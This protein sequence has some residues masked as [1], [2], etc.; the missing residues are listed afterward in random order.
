VIFF[1]HAFIT[2]IWDKI[3]IANLQK[4]LICSSSWGDDA[5]T[6]LN[7]EKSGLIMNHAYT[8]MNTYIITDDEGKEIKLLKIKNP[9]GHKEWKGDWS[10]EWLG[11]NQS[12]LEEFKNEIDF[13]SQNDGVFFIEFEDYLMNF[14]ATIICKISQDFVHSQPF[15]CKQEEN[16]FTL[17]KVKVTEKGKVFFIVSQPN[18]RWINVEENYEISVLRMILVKDKGDSSDFSYDYVDG[19]CWKDEDSIIEHD[20][21]PGEY[22]VYI[23]FHW[24]D[25]ENYNNFIFRTYSKF[26]PEIEEIKQDSNIEFL[27]KALKSLAR[28]DQNKVYY[29][30]NGNSI[31]YLLGKQ[32]DIFRS[33]SIK[34]SKAEYGYVYYE[35]NTE[36]IIL[37]EEIEFENNTNIFML[38]HPDVDSTEVIVSPRSYKII[39]LNRSDRGCLLDI[40][41]KTISLKNEHYQDNEENQNINLITY[42]SEKYDMQ[43]YQQLTNKG[44]VWVVENLSE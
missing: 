31:Y 20:C 8:V 21:T 22:L 44:L 15:Q 9:W 12:W 36:D 2:D 39:I 18:Q 40:N 4:Y 25:P 23:E 38:S 35:N 16:M 13:K 37:T 42:C 28:T 6:D 41:F 14:R 27:E 11:W 1:K 43:Y 19:T 3:E 24:N 33:F 26:E 10:D 17:F 29:K 30:D 32:L 7:Y 5:T 34:E